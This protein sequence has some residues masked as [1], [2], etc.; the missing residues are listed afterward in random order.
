VACKL[1]HVLYAGFKED[2]SFRRLL[3]GPSCIYT[4]FEVIEELARQGVLAALCLK[5]GGATASV[6]VL[7]ISARP[8]R[9]V[10]PRGLARLLA[11][12][13]LRGLLTLAAWLA[14]APRYARAYSRLG[15]ACHLLF[16]ASLAPGRGYGSKLLRRVEELCRSAGARTV[17]LE[18]DIGKPA[19][20]FY[21]KRGYTPLA[22]T[23]FAGRYYLLM[24]K[25]I[26][27]KPQGALGMRKR[28]ADT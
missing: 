17:A 8:S 13:R 5:V 12:L 4:F 14:W 15:E 1:A 28:R 6:A 9:V 2:P 24:A 16:I 20:L 3:G 19:L 21:A 18:V 7:S 27:E 26:G 11:C 23:V 10:L 22:L 25:L